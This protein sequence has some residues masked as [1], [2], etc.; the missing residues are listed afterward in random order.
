MWGR[1]GATTC[2]WTHAPGDDCTD[3]TSTDYTDYTDSFCSRLDEATSLRTGTGAF[4]ASGAVSSWRGGLLQ[5]TAGR[6]H[7]DRTTDDANT[8]ASRDSRTAWKVQAR[9]HRNDHD[10]T[11]DDSPT[12]GCPPRLT[13][14]SRTTMQSVQSVDINRWVSSHSRRNHQDR[15]RDD[16]QGARARDAA[17]MPSKINNTI[18]VIRGYQIRAIGSL[19][20]LGFQ[21]PG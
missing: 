5:D 19:R 8:V 21:L 9:R 3:V 17:R 4:T 15:N 6:I 7:G 10:H 1:T 2:R 18:R 14:G 13:R 20:P 16:S 11:D 12:P